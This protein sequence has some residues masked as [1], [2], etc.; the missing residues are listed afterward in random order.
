MVDPFIA[1]MAG[2]WL[3]P[4]LAFA[5]VLAAFAV[6]AAEVPVRPHEGRVGRGITYIHDQ[7]PSVPWSIHILKIRRGHP[8]FQLHTTLGNGS[9]FG[10][11]CVS[12]QMR[13]VPSELGTAVGGINGDFYRDSEEYPGRPRD[14]QILRGELVSSASGNPVF[15]IQPDGT[16]RI[17]NLVSR[18]RVVWPDGTGTPVGLNEERE[19]DGVVLYTG[20]VGTSTHTSGGTEYVLERG[21]R[22]PWLPL[23]VGKTLFGRVREVHSAGDTRIAP[24]TVVLS[25]GPRAVVPQ[26]APRATF[27]VGTETFPNLE[28]VQTAIGGGPTLVRNGQPQQWSGIQMRHPRSA[29]GYNAEY[30]FLVEVDGRQGRLSLGMSLPELAAYMAKLGCDFAMNLDGGGSA[31]LWVYGN[32]MN[33]PSEGRERPAANALVV[34]ERPRKARRE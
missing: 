8:D 33:S 21:D 15:W 17:T 3:A 16:P 9:W 1:R 11:A 22:D 23:A 2:R 19:P 29:I 25:V 28:G 13:T 27:Q 32:V 4:V 10:M 6:R 34:V 12:D 18:L 31:T 26:A 30:V 7:D 14:L 24:G 20:A 5:S